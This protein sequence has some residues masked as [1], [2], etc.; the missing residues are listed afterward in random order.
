MN[1]LETCIRTYFDTPVE[2]TARIATLFKEEN[3][4][5]NE[6]HTQVGQRHGALSFVREGHLRIYAPS[7]NR[8]VTQWISS[9]G[10]F[11]TD[12]ST[13]VFQQP[14][15]WNIQ[16]LTDCSLFSISQTDYLRIP[17][18]VPEWVSLERLF[19]AKCFLTMEQRIFDFISLSAEERYRV[20]FEEK[21]ELF[22]QV[23]LQH[24]ASM[25]GMTPETFS[26]VRKKML[27]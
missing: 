21:R 4:P 8:E 20:L 7:D 25:L 14:A 27:S 6:F 19:L 16:A 18:L 17:E 5:R 3:L 10:E 26:R 2:I 24:L 12:L 23:P 15:R 22:Q 11:A 13:L 9:P 1:E